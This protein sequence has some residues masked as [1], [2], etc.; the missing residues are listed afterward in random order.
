MNKLKYKAVLFDLDGTLLDTRKGV[1]SAVKKTIYDL[2]LPVLTEEE[3]DVF[4][5]P[6]MQNSFEKYYG[7]T[8]EKALK[9]AN[10]F[11]ENYKNY[12]LLE[13]ELYPGILNMLD[14]LNRT[15]IKIAIATNKSHENAKAIL[16]YYGITDRCQYIKGADLDGKLKKADILE[17]CL[18]ELGVKNNETILVG[19]SEYD[20]IG[21]QK[22][23]I[24][25]LAV[26]YGFDFT[27]DTDFTKINPVIVC[28][29]VEEVYNFF[30]KE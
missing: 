15:G 21:A 23:G 9:S 30:F 5:G 1:K 20:S 25:F 17:I 3:I 12:S 29:N 28:D 7:M 4:V 2:K 11:R 13:A 14:E 8:P 10:L 16:D 24:D 6:P 18:K 27:K 22:V 19:D 26:T